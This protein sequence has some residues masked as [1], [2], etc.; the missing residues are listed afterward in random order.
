MDNLATELYLLEN[1]PHQSAVAPADPPSTFWVARRSA[2]PVGF[3]GMAQRRA[4]RDVKF[5]LNQH[6][7]AGRRS[8]S[9]ESVPCQSDMATDNHAQALGAD[10]I[11][12]PP[13]ANVARRGPEQRLG[14]RN[15][16]VGVDVDRFDAAPGPSASAP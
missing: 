14:L 10:V 5:W 1:E 8:I 4:S 16:A 9:T 11:D 12:P 7:R 2:K 15:H 3:T 6:L 13:E